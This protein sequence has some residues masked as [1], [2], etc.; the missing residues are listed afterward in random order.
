[1]LDLAGSGWLAPRGRCRRA[2]A[3]P[4]WIHGCLALTEQ[5]SVTVE[6]A[7]PCRSATGGCLINSV[8]PGIHGR[9]SLETNACSTRPD[10][11][12]GTQSLPALAAR[13]IRPLVRLSTAV[14]FNPDQADAPGCSQRTDRWALRDD[15][16]PWPGRRLATPGSYPSSA[17]SRW[18]NG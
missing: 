5:A 12:A 13:R 1:V 10:G 4:G 18:R 6:A 8:R 16:E 2:P 11:I 14:F 7:G 3:T 15:P 17:G 9:N